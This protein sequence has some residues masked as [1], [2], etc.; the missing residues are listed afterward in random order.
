MDHTAGD[1]DEK[2]GENSR[3]YPLLM[4]DRV[5]SRHDQWD[6]GRTKGVAAANKLLEAEREVAVA[7]KTEAGPD[8]GCSTRPVHNVDPGLK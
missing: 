2:S 7:L 1:H 3:R 8:A 6:E 4:S 5:F